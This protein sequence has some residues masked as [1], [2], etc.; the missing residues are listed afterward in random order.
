MAE[1]VAGA[2]RAMFIVCAF[3]FN[4]QARDGLQDVLKSIY[5]K[6]DEYAT[7]RF[8][9]GRKWV[10]RFM[11]IDMDLLEKVSDIINNWRDPELSDWMDNL[12]GSFNALSV[13]VSVMEMSFLF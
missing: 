10:M 6:G 1:V 12:L 9:A 4:P 2:F 8:G 11:L 7:N 13:A 5:F 3:S